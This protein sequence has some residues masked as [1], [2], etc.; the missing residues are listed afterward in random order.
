[1]RKSLLLAST[2]A[3]AASLVAAPA[4]NAAAT[5]AAKTPTKV[6]FG[7][8]TTWDAK[9]KIWGKVT[10]TGTTVP[11]GK[12]LVAECYSYQWHKWQAV[13]PGKGQKPLITQAGGSFSSDLTVYCSHGKYRVRFPGDPTLA[14]ST[15]PIVLDKRINALT[16]GW[17]VTPKSIRKNGYV[18]FSGTLKHDPTPGH[19]VPFKGQ[20]VYLYVK[21]K[22]EKKWYWFARPKTDSKGHFSGR[23]RIPRDASFSYE[24]FGD[25]THY[26]DSPLK[27]TFVN[28]R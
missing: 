28:V 11:A 16:F 6:T 1:M 2:A 24:Y 15:S 12:W 7:M 5:P 9:L 27:A 19:Y 17:K 25:K 10:A 18:Y 3:A 20:R 13:K 14:P 4:A 21:F 23:F 8:S 22:G 26:Y